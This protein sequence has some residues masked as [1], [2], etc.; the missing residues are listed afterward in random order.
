MKRPRKFTAVH[1][2]GIIALLVFMATLSLTPLSRMAISILAERELGEL[3]GGTVEIE[4]VGG[5]PFDRFS[6]ETVRFRDGEKVWATAEAIV[7]SWSPLELLRRRVA[8]NELTIENAQLFSRPPQNPDKSRFK[9][10]EL[11]GNLPTISLAKL[12]LENL[13]V[14]A[15][16][17]GK[18]LRVDG[19]GSIILEEDAI[20]IHINLEGTGQRDRLA[21]R[22]ERAKGHGELALKVALQSNADGL[23]AALGRTDG[24]IDIS[25]EGEGN[26]RR[27]EARFDGFAGEI[28]SVNGVLIGNL[29]TFERIEFDVVATPG[30]RFGRLRDE[31]GR[32]L[33]L[34]G[35][36][37]PV[38][39]GG[40]IDLDEFR[41]DFGRVAGAIEWKNGKKELL[42][43]VTTLQ[44]DLSEGWRPE[45]QKALGSHID[46]KLTLERKQS[47]YVGAA[48]IRAEE[49]AIDL[50]ELETDLRSLA[51]AKLKALLPR[52]SE[53]A[54]ALNSPVQVEADLEL[55]AGQRLEA[56]QLKISTQ[57]GFSF[58]GG[59]SVLIRSGFMEAVGTFT[60]N[61]EAMKLIAPPLSFSGSAIGEVAI[62]GDK[63]GL[64][65]KIASRTPEL[66]Y[67]AFPIPASRISID[68]T[69]QA[70]VISALVSA[71]ANDRSSSSSFK[72]DR[73]KDGRVEIVE[74]RH[75]GPGFE[76]NGGVLFDSASH[77][78]EADLRYSG[79]ADAEPL[80]GVPL[81]GRITAIGALSA[82]RANGRFEVN[83]EDLRGD[84]WGVEDLTVIARGPTNN[85]SFEV[86]SETV[87]ALSRMEL[88]NLKITGA[89]KFGDNSIVQ[90]KSGSASFG[91]SKIS[92]IDEAALRFGSEFSFSAF[93][94]RVGEMGSIELSG[95]IDRR[96][97]LAK[98]NVRN[99]QLEN[100]DA[101]VDF[102]MDL[103]TNA[104][105]AA[106]GKF[107]AVS[108]LAP[109]N[110]E[111]LTGSYSWSDGRLRILAGG[112]Q[113]LLDFDLDI[114]LEIQRSDPI[115][116]RA[117]GAL[118]GEARFSGPVDT[119][120][121]FLPGPLQTLEG[122]LDVSGALTGTLS[123]PKIAGE[124]HL[125][126]GA[127]TDPT[128]GVSIVNI[129]FE[130]VATGS[131]LASIIE[132]SGTASGAGQT[133][134]T[135]KASGRLNITD[136]IS[137]L[138]TVEF[139]DARFS[140][141]PVEKIEASGSLSVRGDINDLL[142]SGDISVEE[143]EAKLFTP[144]T[145]GLVDIDVVVA[146]H[147]DEVFVRESRPPRRS[148]ANYAVRVS[149]DD[150]I[151][152]KGRGLNSEWRAD[153]QISGN[154]T[155]PLILG[156]MTLV[157]GDLEFSGRRF[158]LTRGVLAF[159][160][161]SPNDPTIDLR[162]ERETRDGTT[163]SVQI[164]GR[165]S[166]MKVA[167]ESAPSRTNED[168]MALVLFDKTAD[169]LSPFQ[170]FQV[171]DALTQLGG[172]GVFG[173]KG[174]AGAA[175]DALGL[176]LLNI[177]FDQSD[178]SASQL[179]VGKYVTGGL[180][181]TASQNARGENGSLR[182]E[183]EIGQSF[184]IE[185][186]LKQD[187][188]QKISGNWK[189]DF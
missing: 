11:P 35:D 54:A 31:L 123:S 16:L 102:S 68:A 96:R 46:A 171:A 122:R 33:K 76:L 129:D 50:T 111:K 26:L 75:W 107:M 49:I 114:P 57:T 133:A 144:P 170:S 139:Q 119:I 47:R 161:L 124:L 41:T 86:S 152:I 7:I 158:N 176:D 116:F 141:G 187:G 104:K 164:S 163:V 22:I 67:Q 92:L 28:G 24:P 113:N 18:H 83:A 52:E 135:I 44:I 101:L 80:P 177:D 169:Q 97:W 130:A 180:F 62:S 183:Y 1:T 94:L 117:A 81:A 115:R 61:D 60:T 181:I 179:T 136:A 155:G 85:L 84:Q 2:I 5:N 25:I 55:G 79:D 37:R 3:T 19:A 34:R 10:L 70:D 154:V 63:D 151:T 36:F 74:L 105:V 165:S 138:T 149:A 38:E 146:G 160:M 99:L 153:V 174:F 172:V 12:N 118:Q 188:D 93:A 30:K 103:D 87:S 175:Q 9:G 142:V 59:A 156:N 53:I 66:Q 134:K 126:D 127:I 78:L 45:L 125:V 159:D 58:D 128:T 77:G 108:T 168:V 166:A 91:A 90:I 143:L 178:S 29:E 112:G 4:K 106:F 98:A 82:R 15:G 20:S 73:G 147:G 121:V 88:R 64:K 27:Y 39:S 140:A 43:G 8:L 6:I 48:S 186:E 120:A 23:F 148:S 189:R 40:S 100:S 150:K 69:Y 72:V 51:N 110:A 56:R 21:I 65:L 162:A 109:P 95:A 132:F 145:D 14:D 167:L 173:G 131:A 157:R 182:I 32:T 184:S 185:T 13:Q 42:S 137:L 17:V 89:A 71:Q